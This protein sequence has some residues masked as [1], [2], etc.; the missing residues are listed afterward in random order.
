MSR[1]ATAADFTREIAEIDAH[2]AATEAVEAESLSARIMN[3]G[4]RYRRAELVAEMEALATKGRLAH[5]LDVVLDGDPVVHHTIEARFLSDIL[6]DF[7]GLV[8]DLLADIAGRLG[9]AGKV[10]KAFIERTQLRV[11]TTYPGSFGLR[12]EAGVG[13]FHLDDA[14]SFAETMAALL[15][16]ID[17]TPDQAAFISEFEPLSGR[18]K[19]KFMALLEHLAD[20]NASIRVSWPTPTGARESQ[21]RA[22]QA[23]ER[24]TILEKFEESSHIEH[25]DGVLDSAQHSRATFL[26]I[27]DDRNRRRISGTIEEH[28]VDEM[29]KYWGKRVRAM[30]SVRELVPEVGK[31]YKFYRLS[32]IE[33]LEEPE[34]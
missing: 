6:G 27:P 29:G 12:F 10:A 24:L 23:R 16:L 14:G 21:L 25:V 33:L 3:R 28:L 32:R 15:N 1:L 17:A 20:A 7:Q 2:L 5:E 18:T 30:F 22:S 31:V 34:E 26:I 8:R 11:A 9:K 4:L 13:E 19:T